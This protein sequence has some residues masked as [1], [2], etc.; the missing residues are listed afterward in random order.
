[1]GS[2]RGLEGSRL[3]TFAFGDSVVQPAVFRRLGVI[4][5]PLETF[6]AEA[7]SRTDGVDLPSFVE[8][9]FRT[10]LRCGLLVHGFA[11][12][13]CEACATPS[14][15]TRS[16]RSAASPAGRSRSERRAPAPAP[17]IERRG[18]AA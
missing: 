2:R 13:R 18:P 8:R 10:F 16:G 4:L 14:S 17:P 1:M 11:R 7:A 15:S 6:L 5:S 3:S 9:E 12:V